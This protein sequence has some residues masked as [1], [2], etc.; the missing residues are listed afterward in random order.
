MEVIVSPTKKINQVLSDKGNIMADNAVTTQMA[1]KGDSM[2]TEKVENVQMEA[3]TEQEPLLVE[4]LNQYV[5]FPIKH[6]QMW[7]M[8]KELVGNFWSPTE[9]LQNLDSYALNESEIDFLKSV[10]GYYASPQSIGL[11]NENLAEEFSKVIQVT[12]A[13]FFF[14]HQTF[15]QNMHYEMYN[16]IFEKLVPSTE[17][18]EKTFHVI[19]QQHTLDGK[20]NWLNSWHQSNNFNHQLVAAACMHGLFFAVINLICQWLNTRSKR[21]LSQELLEI[22]QKMAFEQDLQRDFACLMISN[23]KNKPTRDF[24][25]QMVLQTA[26]IEFE[27]LNELNFDKIGIDA[28]DLLHMIDT[29]VKLLKGKLLDSIITDNKIVNSKASSA[30]L[31]SKYAASTNS[32]SSMMENQ[33]QVHAEANSEERFK[34]TFDEDF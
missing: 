1:L 2:D 20:I 9:A 14:G 13:K 8:Y 31:T 21:M 29:R 30:S 28:K 15:V 4:S 16:K 3:E 19:Q 18:R 24:V 6:D 11:V 25:D 23:L 34:L 33:M 32:M 5:I 12:E 17:A 10:S 26:K 7:H 27:F 22:F